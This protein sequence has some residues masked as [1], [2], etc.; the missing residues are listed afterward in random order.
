VPTRKSPP[1]AKRKS[2]LVTAM[3]QA[4]ADCPF[5]LLR[6]AQRSFPRVFALGWQ[7]Y[8]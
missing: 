5:Q 1:H 7:S 4:L 6:K 3:A 8:S 2:L